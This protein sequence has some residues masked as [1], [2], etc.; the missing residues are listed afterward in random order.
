MQ[1]YDDAGHVPRRF[2]D[3]RRV[4]L[5]I[6]PIVKTAG[7]GNIQLSLVYITTS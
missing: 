4:V 5:K 6:R 2:D 3:A 1:S 7:A